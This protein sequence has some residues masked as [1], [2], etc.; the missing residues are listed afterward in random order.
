MPLLRN[1]GFEIFGVE[2]FGVEICDE[3]RELTRRR[4]ERLGILVSLRTANSSHIPFDDARST[5]C[6]PA[7]RVTT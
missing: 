2:I 5:S 4:M 7:I 1:L 3:V 6:S